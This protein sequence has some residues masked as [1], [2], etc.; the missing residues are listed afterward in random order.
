MS[1][2]GAVDRA[3]EGAEP[4]P[5][6]RF[7]LVMGTL[8]NRAPLREATTRLS[9]SESS[10]AYTSATVVFLLEYVTDANRPYCADGS[11][12]SGTTFNLSA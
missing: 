9:G 1:R 11:T 3:C 2:G 5:R 6:A 7:K 12:I 10:Q 4:A 8:R